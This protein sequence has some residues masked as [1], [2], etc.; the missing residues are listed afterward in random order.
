[1]PRLEQRMRKAGQRWPQRGQLEAQ[2]RRTSHGAGDRRQPTTYRQLHPRAAQGP[3]TLLAPRPVL[4]A[5][6]TAPQQNEALAS[7]GAKPPG[8]PSSRIRLRSPACPRRCFL[9]LVVNA[10]MPAGS[11]GGF[12]RRQVRRLGMRH[13]RLTGGSLRETGAWLQVGS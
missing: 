6:S 1:M 8:S 2:R 7:P 5:P 10:L 11:G 9:P 3:A 13:P 12:P 4:L